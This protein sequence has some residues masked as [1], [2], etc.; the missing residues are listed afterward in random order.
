[1]GLSQGKRLVKGRLGLFK[2]AS[3]GGVNAFVN[4][5]MHLVLVFV[6]VAMGRVAALVLRVIFP[7]LRRWVVC[8]HAS[9]LLSTFCLSALSL[10]L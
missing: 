4:E 5:A 10:L 6:K 2:L 1:M 3:F 8:G 7:V 9:L